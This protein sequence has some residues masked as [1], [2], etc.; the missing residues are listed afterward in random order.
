M[1]K[2]IDLIIAMLDDEEGISEKT[3]NALLIWVDTFSPKMVNVLTTLVEASEGRFYLE[4][5]DVQAC[6]D[7]LNSI[8]REETR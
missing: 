7:Q 3:Y 2:E 1:K 6:R 5:G 4:E 8:V